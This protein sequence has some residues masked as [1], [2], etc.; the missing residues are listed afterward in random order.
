MRF[1]TPHALVLGLGLL[2]LS[3]VGAQP[4]TGGGFASATPAPAASAKPGASALPAPDWSKQLIGRWQTTDLDKE[5]GV[6]TRTEIEF[7]SDG[8]YVTRLISN[9]FAEVR[10]PAGGRYRIEKPDGSGFT[11]SVQR[12]LRDPESDKAE[13]NESQRISALDADTLQAADGSTVRRLK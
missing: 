6:S 10:Q 5:S 8:S 11:L 9:R 2:G 3:Q 4:P 1:P 12:E 13:A 7:R